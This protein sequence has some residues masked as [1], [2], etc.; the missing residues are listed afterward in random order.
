MLQFREFEN[1]TYSVLLQYFLDEENVTIDSLGNALLLLLSL[2]LLTSASSVDLTIHGCSVRLVNNLS[3]CFT[4]GGF[5]AFIADEKQISTEKKKGGRK[6]PPGA[7]F[8]NFTE[9]LINTPANFLLAPLSG[10]L[11]L[12]CPL[13]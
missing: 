7:R 9:F 2:S 10:I 13:T 8:S 11:P 12:A 5:F 1:Y 4:T 3:H 6:R